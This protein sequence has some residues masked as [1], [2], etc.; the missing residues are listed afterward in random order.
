MAQPPEI[1]N[2]TFLYIL[3]GFGLQ[4]LKAKYRIQYQYQS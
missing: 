4:F 3:M 1:S 2:Y